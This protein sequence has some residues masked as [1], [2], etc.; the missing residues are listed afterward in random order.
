LGYLGL[1]QWPSDPIIERSS[2]NPSPTDV[3]RRFR[4]AFQAFHG[5]APYVASKAGGWHYVDGD[6]PVRTAQLAQQADK[7]ERGV[8]ARTRQTQAAA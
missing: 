4:E 8:Q 6:G 2:M 1:V 3:V 7:W 5:Y